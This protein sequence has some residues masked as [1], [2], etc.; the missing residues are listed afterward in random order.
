VPG[1]VREY[2]VTK[3]SMGSQNAYG[4]ANMAL[5]SM[6]YPC[7]VSKKTIQEGDF[8]QISTPLS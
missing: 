1:I 5:Q 6:S 8:F 7:T 2:T 3:G 4:L